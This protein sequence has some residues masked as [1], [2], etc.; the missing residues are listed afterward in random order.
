MK[1]ELLNIVSLL[2]EE[3][4][5]RLQDGITDLLLERIREDLDD[6]SVCLMDLEAMLDSIRK[7]IEKEAKEKI[8]NM[9]MKKLERKLNEENY[10]CWNI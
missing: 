5:K 3:N 6:V 9:Y 1:D 8:K 4:K 7:D 10:F 2:G